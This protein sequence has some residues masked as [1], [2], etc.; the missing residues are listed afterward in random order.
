MLLFREHNMNSYIQ[1]S[2]RA[3]SENPELY[4][5]YTEESKE[6]VERVFQLAV[7]RM[8]NSFQPSDMDL[9]YPCNF[10]ALGKTTHHKNADML[11]VSISFLAS[12]K[13]HSF[14]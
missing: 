6:Q 10:F 11:V 14:L 3:E 1:V 8:I 9:N 2:K 12:V 4:A 13:L 5:E 7:H